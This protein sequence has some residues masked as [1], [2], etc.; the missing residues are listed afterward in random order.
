MLI[1]FPTVSSLFFV[2]ELPY[3]HPVGSRL[4][5]LV[6]EEFVEF[7]LIRLQLLSSAGLHLAKVY[8]DCCAHSRF[9]LGDY[10]KYPMKL[11]ALLRMFQKPDYT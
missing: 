4:E 10:F 7:L 3:P 1:S 5:F 11:S 2:L 8:L 6:A 9:L